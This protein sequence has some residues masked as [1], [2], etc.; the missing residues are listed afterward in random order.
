MVTSPTPCAVNNGPG[1]SAPS[2]SN[3]LVSTY[4]TSNTLL[5]YLSKNTPALKNIEL[6]SRSNTRNS[7]H[8]VACGGRVGNWLTSAVANS[9]RTSLPRSLSRSPYR[10]AAMKEI[11]IKHFLRILV[12]EACI[13]SFKSLDGACCTWKLAYRWT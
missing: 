13:W 7:M 2:E 12:G 11:R 1:L 4:F 5:T 9:G 6:D 8:E 3:P 10:S